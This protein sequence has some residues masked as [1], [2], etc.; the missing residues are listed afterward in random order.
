MAAWLGVVLL[1]LVWAADG[2]VN[3]CKSTFFVF[4]T[5]RCVDVPRLGRGGAAGSVRFGG[6]HD[7]KGALQ[8]SGAMQESPNKPPLKTL[9]PWRVPPASRPC[10]RPAPPGRCHQ[11][12]RRASMQSEFCCWPG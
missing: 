6:T 5:A 11:L 2:Q 9:Q 1:L 12:C 4:P 7:G 8:L 3:S 10:R